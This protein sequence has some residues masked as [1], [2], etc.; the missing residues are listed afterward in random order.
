MNHPGAP[1]NAYTMQMAPNTS[2]AIHITNLHAAMMAHAQDPFSEFHDV[3]AR[4]RRLLESL[5][6]VAP[7]HEFR[8][9]YH[10]FMATGDPGVD[11][12][13]FQAI[14]PWIA[15]TRDLLL[16]EEFD[17][18]EISYEILPYIFPALPMQPPAV[19]PPPPAD[20]GP[21]PLQSPN[22]HLP[23]SPP[24]AAS[25]EGSGAQAE[26]QEVVDVPSSPEIIMISSN[27]EEEE[28]PEE[29][30]GEVDNV[31]GEEGD[32]SSDPDYDPSLGR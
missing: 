19:P 25:E 28:D 15:V 7:W 13:R 21:S 14:G 31:S 6:L 30:E 8:L 24:Q 23:V 27:E 3:V 32:D 9:R 22:P 20:Q 29:D 5:P 16:R 1:A 2:M 11:A 12:E 18:R 4:T 26:V 17:L 10:E